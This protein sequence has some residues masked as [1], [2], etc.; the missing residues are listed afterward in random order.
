MVEYKKTLG[1]IVGVANH[2]MIRSLDRIL[3]ERK[4]PITAEQFKLMTHLWEKDGISQ[5]EIALKLG[6]NRAATGRMLEVLEKKHLIK[7]MGHPTDKRLNLV[8]LTKSGKKIE[9]LANK[10]AVAVIE[11]SQT[12]ISDSELELIKQLLEKIIANLK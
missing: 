5:R 10:A 3:A 7:R 4:I 12:N 8:F 1:R 2:L 11:K 6:R 9:K